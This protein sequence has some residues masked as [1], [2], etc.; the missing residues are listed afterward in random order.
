MT[1]GSRGSGPAG[2][3]IDVRQQVAEIERVL[4]EGVDP[5]GCLRALSI[6]ERWQFDEM[7]DDGS[8]MKARVLVREFAAGWRDDAWRRW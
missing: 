3:R 6:L 1:D 2:S 4:R 5:A 7:L 8:R